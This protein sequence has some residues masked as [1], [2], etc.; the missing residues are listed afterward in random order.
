MGDDKSLVASM[1]P[2]D[3]PGGNAHPG[4]V[5]GAAG[6]GASMRPPDLPGGNR[7][8]N[9]SMVAYVGMLQ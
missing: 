2:P 3:L 6:A 7:Y 8:R 4:A 1:R 5:E 9:G